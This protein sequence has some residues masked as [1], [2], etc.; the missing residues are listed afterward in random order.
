MQTRGDKTERTPTTQ[1]E[2]G[3]QMNPSGEEE[4]Q[5]AT[6]HTAY[7]E[8]NLAHATSQVTSSEEKMQ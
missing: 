7:Q 3:Q 4:M 1:A 5:C 2:A 6:P 8:S